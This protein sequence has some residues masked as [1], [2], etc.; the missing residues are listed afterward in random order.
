MGQVSAP[1]GGRDT[2]SGSSPTLDVVIPAFNSEFR[3]L[4]ILR[5]LLDQQDVAFDTLVVDN[6][7]T[8]GTRRV[9]EEFGL[10]NSRQGRQFIY[11][12]EQKAG[13]QYAR[14]LGVRSSTAQWIAFLDDDNIP[15][16]GWI[17]AALRMA[18]SQPGARAFHGRNFAPAE[19][20]SHP[21]F[22]YAKQFLAIHDLGDLPL[23]Y[24]FPHGRNF[25]PTAGLVVN[26]ELFVRHCLGKQIL[27]GPSRDFPL[28]AEDM[29]LCAR[30]VRD[31]GLF[32]VPAMKLTHDIRPDRLSDETIVRQYRVAGESAH[33]PRLLKVS[34]SWRL[35]VLVFAQLRDV[36][37][38]LS[39]R[40]STRSL[41]TEEDRQ[42]HYLLHYFRGSLASPWKTTALMGRD[43]RFKGT[44]LIARLLCLTH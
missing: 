42:N 6:G 44:G 20:G 17:A 28:V 41:A 14:E 15:H 22:R 34:P 31:R 7:S 1:T 32:Y 27:M 2:A 35:P 9:V 18:A 8:D 38:I 26:R 19:V 21:N 5:A 36:A 3:I 16:E 37:K 12:Q 4:K 40:W 25:A 43:P 13:A 39:L 30:L 23:A 10:A 29:E 11:L 24:D 33:V